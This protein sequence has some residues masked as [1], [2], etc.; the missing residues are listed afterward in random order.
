MLSRG[1]TAHRVQDGRDVVRFWQCWVPVALLSLV[2]A[3]QLVT[4]GQAL[5]ALLSPGL[6]PV[7]MLPLGRVESRGLEPQDQQFSL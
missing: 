6:D 3:M 2:S 5:A 4:E 1:S 7:A